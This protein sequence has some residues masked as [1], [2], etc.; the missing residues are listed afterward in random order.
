MS[1]GKVDGEEENALGDGQVAKLRF[2]SS[3]DMLQGNKGS[4]VVTYIL[5]F[6]ASPDAFLCSLILTCSFYITALSI[7]LR[8]SQHLLP[9]STITRR[10]ALHTFLLHALPLLPLPSCAKS[11]HRPFTTTPT[12]SLSSLLPHPHPPLHHRLLQH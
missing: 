4:R 3:H 1:A 6:N 10:T 7:V 11:L 5:L 9:L 8:L 12:L 2:I